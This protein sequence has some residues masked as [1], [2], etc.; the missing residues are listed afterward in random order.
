MMGII[1]GTGMLG[2]AIADALLDRGGVA[3][4]ELWVSSRRG[5]AALPAAVHQTSIHQ[6]LVD[7]CDLVLLCVPPQAA[8][9]LDID[10]RGRLV[11]SVMAGVSLARLSAVT[12]ADRV[13]RAISS[14]AAARGLAFSPWVASATVTGNDRRQVAGL[15][16]ACGTSVEVETEDQIDLFTA[17]TGPVPGF[18]AFFAACMVD[19]ATTRGVAPKIADQAVRQLFLGAGHLMAEGDMTPAGHVRQMIDYGGT[20]AAG[21]TRL[22]HSGVPA[23]LGDALDASVE[24]TR[25]IATDD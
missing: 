24:K 18:V 15:L 2:S 21:L 17:M 8:G 19:Y 4:D 14:P 9:G 16:A 12:G 23:A 5:S 22:H 1:G 20:T 6:D 13:V 25:R 3:P 11:L 10:A 7:A